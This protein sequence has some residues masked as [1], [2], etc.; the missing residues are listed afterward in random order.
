MP[1]RSGDT[2]VLVWVALLVLL[3]MA[4]WLKVPLG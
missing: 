3:V 2:S 4:L 1:T